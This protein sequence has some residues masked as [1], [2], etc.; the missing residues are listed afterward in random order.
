MQRKRDLGK[1]RKFRW[2]NRVSEKGKRQGN[3]AGRREEKGN[4]K[5]REC[6]ILSLEGKEKGTS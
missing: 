5:R 1:R 4:G 6:K 2:K 3:E